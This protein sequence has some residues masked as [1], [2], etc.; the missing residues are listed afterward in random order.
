MGEHGEGAVIAA[1]SLAGVVLMRLLRLAGVVLVRL[2]ARRLRLAGVV[3]VRLLARR[4]RLAA[5]VLVRLLTA[6]AGL[7]RPAGCPMRSGAG[8]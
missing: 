3:L 7:L 2:L 1:R 6:G 4:L 8:L 5:V